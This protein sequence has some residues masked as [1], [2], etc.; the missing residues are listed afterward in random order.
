MIVAGVQSCIG[1]GGAADDNASHG[2]CLIMQIGD[3]I[4]F[5]M[6]EISYQED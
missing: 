6:V 5:V 1:V 2:V 4:A 3:I